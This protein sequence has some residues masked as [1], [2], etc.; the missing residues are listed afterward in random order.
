[1]NNHSVNIAGI[2]LAA[3]TS[4][5]M[6]QPKQL[7]TLKGKTLLAWVIEAAIQSSLAQVILVLG[8]KAAEIQKSLDYPNISI[9]HNPKY[10]Q[11]QSSSVRHGIK[12][13]NSSIDAAIFLLG[14]QPLIKPKTI[15]TLIAAYM[16]KQSLIIVPSYQGKRGNPVI[17]DRRLFPQ[18]ETLSG[19]SGGKALFNKNADQLTM[20]DVDDPGIHA[21]IDTLNDYERLKIS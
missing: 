1:M 3:G 8:Y 5:R 19:D 4:S 21:D 15:N 11:G 12:T 7:L 9:I 18:L 17:F 10:Q 14:D 2:I 16:E 20:I 13:L 6:G